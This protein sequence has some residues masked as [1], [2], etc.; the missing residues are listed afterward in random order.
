MSGL[1]ILLEAATVHRHTGFKPITDFSRTQ[2]EEISYKHED[3]IVRQKGTTMIGRNRVRSVQDAIT[4]QYANG[5]SSARLTPGTGRF[6]PFVGFHI[7]VGRDSELDAAMQAAKI[8]QIEIKHQRPG[9]AEIVRHW[10]LGESIKFYPITSGPIAPTVAASL[11][12]RNMRATAEAGIGMRWG[13]GERSRMAL[14]GYVDT[15]VRTGYIRLFQFSVRSRMTDVLLTALL[16]HGRVCEAADNL[17][18]R[19]KHREV[20]T[21]HEVALPLG[22]GNEEE[23]GKGDTAT[24]VPFVSLHPQAID[25]EYL[26]SVWRP[27]A[28]HAAAIKDWESIQFWAQDYAVQSEEMPIR[29]SDEIPV[30]GAEDLL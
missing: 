16:D 6:T 12:E 22:P 20:V 29:Q 15:L 30:N 13:A 7:E 23:W 11:A 17:I 5:K 10:N 9:G 21:Y 19:S 28:V 27:E 26:R 8:N 14:R 18:D 1:P 2:W 24:V 25:A 3:K 4:L